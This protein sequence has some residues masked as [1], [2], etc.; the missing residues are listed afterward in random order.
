[1]KLQNLTTAFKDLRMKDYEIFDEFHAKLSHIAHS[2]FNLGG[3]IYEAELLIKFKGCFPK[4]FAQKWC[5]YWGVSK[6]R[7]PHSGK[8]G[9]ESENLWTQSLLN[10]IG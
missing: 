8:I 5:G 6:S 4:G 2:S 1:M 9:S 10:Q 3:L 7:L